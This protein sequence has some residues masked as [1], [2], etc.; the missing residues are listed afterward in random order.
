MALPIKTGVEDIEKL[1]TLLAK[2]PTGATAKEA[3]AVMR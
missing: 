2:K 1:C 3:R